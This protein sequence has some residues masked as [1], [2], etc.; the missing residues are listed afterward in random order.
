MRAYV[1]DLPRILLDPSDVRKDV[2]SRIEGKG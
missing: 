1:A 2:A